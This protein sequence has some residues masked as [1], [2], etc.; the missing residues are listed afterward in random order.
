M[1]ILGLDLGTKR[2]G[3]ALSDALGITAQGVT[4]LMRESDEEI[5][6]YVK[7]IV[8]KEHVTEIVIGL[9]LNMDGSEG[10]KAKEA[11]LFADRIKSQTG[12][13]VKLWDERMTTKQAERHMIDADA[14]RAKR[15]RKLDKLAAQLILQGYLDAAGTR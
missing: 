12:I 5:I 3:V 11:I 9:P 14:S 2:V 15:K 13:L 8:S 1:R 10:P 7:D 4:T 6:N